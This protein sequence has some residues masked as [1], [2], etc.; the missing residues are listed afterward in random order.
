MS[1]ERPNKT[2][3]PKALSL[4]ASQGAPKPSSP[5]PLGVPTGPAPKRKNRSER[6]YLASFRRRHSGKPQLWLL[7]CASPTG[8]RARA[9]SMTASP[10]RHNCFSTS[11]QGNHVA[12]TVLREGISFVSPCR[13]A[14]RWAATAK[15]PHHSKPRK[16]S[17]VPSE[18]HHR[19]PH[20]VTAHRIAQA[21]T[22]RA[23][24]PL[25]M[26]SAD[27]SHGRSHEPLPACSMRRPGHTS[28]L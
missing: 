11:A 6:P 9:L 20:L 1:E 21:R 4:P 13:I 16:L 10:H 17:G 2:A 26:C 27:W 19:C 23:G 3:L 8:A 12:I 7:S 14:A 22:G 24:H 15:T 18:G 28:L 25:E 5:P